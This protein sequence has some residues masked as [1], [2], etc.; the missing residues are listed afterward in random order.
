MNEQEVKALIDEFKNS[1]KQ[2]PINITDKDAKAKATK[3]VEEAL[4]LLDEVLDKEGI[5]QIIG[6]SEADIKADIFKP[7]MDPD[8]YIRLEAEAQKGLAETLDE[9]G[10][11]ETASEIREAPR[12]DRKEI[13]QDKKPS[14]SSMT[15][16]EMFYSQDGYDEMS[17]MEE[18][19]K[20]EKI[21]EAQEVPNKPTKTVKAPM[22]QSDE[23]RRFMQK[24]NG[25]LSK[26]NGRWTDTELQEINKYIRTRP[27][28]QKL[29][30][31]NRD[32]IWPLLEEKNI[33]EK[34]LKANNPKNLPTDRPPDYDRQPDDAV[35]TG[36]QN[37]RRTF[38][39]GIE[40][41]F[42]N[43]KEML[44]EG[45]IGGYYQ[46]GFKIK[47]NQLNDNVARGL[48]KDGY[49]VPQEVWEN[50][51]FK[52]GGEDL[53]YNPKKGMYSFIGTNKSDAAKIREANP[54]A[55]NFTPGV[56]V[57]NIEEP[58]QLVG[59]W[60][61]NPE[62]LEMVSET[63]GISKAKLL[64]DY[65]GIDEAG[66]ELVEGVKRSAR[67]KDLRYQDAWLLRIKAVEYT[68]EIF[69]KQASDGFYNFWKPT[70]NG[71]EIAAWENGFNP[72]KNVELGKFITSLGP[73]LGAGLGK[74]ARLLDYG[75][76]IYGWM[77][78]GIGHTI[79]KLGTP[80]EAI[81]KVVGQ[82]AKVG[83][84]P[85]LAGPQVKG[86]P[87]KVLK[88]GQR[89]ATGSVKAMAAY[90]KGNFLYGLASGLILSLVETLGVVAES[91][92]GEA[93][94]REA[95][96]PD[97]Y[98]WAEDNGIIDTIGPWPLINSLR[99]AELE[100]I[101]EPGKV[102][103]FIDWNNDKW[104]GVLYEFLGTEGYD[105][106]ESINT[107]WREKRAPQ[108]WFGS[109]NDVFGL[110][111][112][113]GMMNKDFIPETGLLPAI[114]RSPIVSGIEIPFEQWFLPKVGLE[115]WVIDL[116]DD[117]SD[118]GPGLEQMSGMNLPPEILDENYGGRIDNSMWLKNVMGGDS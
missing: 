2:I 51:D 108:G 15:E 77:A 61:D 19:I 16:E 104:L 90:E 63:T 53:H 26:N 13:I 5:N 84:G 106:M 101:L 4:K 75:E 27:S 88:A 46:A 92:F 98:K 71:M 49:I 89:P 107:V 43:Y 59:Q 99:Q 18:D 73:L 11:R 31:E 25:M 87:G 100:G 14:V 72:L 93:S 20:S 29:L 21:V 70:V 55:K 41:D 91:S 22:P 105:D 76:V 36:Y 39:A 9:T 47:A 109:I 81:S 64:H 80:G 94:I 79:G 111:S 10:Q 48:R 67:Y 45:P 103:E 30:T 62:K 82:G 83:K 44:P 60:W 66:E 42:W 1:L 65:A 35:R 38:L 68:P 40:K 24:I 114:K 117:Y 113:N 78:N 17:Q 110:D 12:E 3:Q 54:N 34:K 50:G 112:K 58:E 85:A 28:L 97:Y 23:Y 8:L 37:T 32:E 96:G 102:D 7:L 69:T 115:D 57:K 56:W 6:M 86:A 52:K 74:T 95:L 116:D 33:T 118:I